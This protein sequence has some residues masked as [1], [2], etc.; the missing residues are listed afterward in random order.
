MCAQVIRC[1]ASPFSAASCMLNPKLCARSG[2]HPT[3]APHSMHGD[4][5]KEKAAGSSSLVSAYRAQQAHTHYPL[6]AYTSP[7]RGTHITVRAT[8]ISNQHQ[9]GQSCLRPRAQLVQH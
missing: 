3:K 2:I 8:Y 1:I 5:E 7:I 9:H 4:A 6:S